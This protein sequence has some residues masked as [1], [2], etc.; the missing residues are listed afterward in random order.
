MKRWLLA[1]SLLLCL[2]S[3]CALAQ[4]VQLEYQVTAYYPHDRKLFTQGLLWHQ[5]LL[6]ESAG[7][8]GQSRLLTRRLSEL[9]PISQRQLDQHYFAEGIAVL[10]ERLYQLNWRAQR[11]FIY[12]P[13]NLEPIASFYYRGEGWGLTSNGRQLIMSN[14]SAQLSF[15]DG[16][17]FG[18]ISQLNVTDQGKPLGRL[19]ELEWVDGLIAAN[20]WQSDTIVFIHPDNGKVVAKLEL[21][22]LLPAQLRTSTTGVLN[23]IAYNAEQ[24]RLYVTGKR[25]PR[26]FEIRILNMPDG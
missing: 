2:S 1:T 12:R 22:S 5:G 3:P 16:D 24:Q 15:R 7:Q 17:D 20:I 14:G 21:G 13:D 25:W 11:G 18:E 19:N 9:S 26:L 8:Y 23:G 6:Y 10:D 4:P